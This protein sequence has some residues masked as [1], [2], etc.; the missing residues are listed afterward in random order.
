MG[1][2]ELQ[3]PGNFRQAEIDKI[4]TFVQ[5]GKFCQLISTPG[6]GK[7]T[8]LRLLAYNPNVLKFHLK[9]KG[10]SINFIYLNLLDL[11]NYQEIEIL[12]YILLALNQKAQSDDLLALNKQLMEIVHQQASLGQTTVFLFDHFDEYQNQLPPSFFQ[13]LR[14]ANR[15]ARYK[16]STVFATR[17]DL[18]ELVDPTTIKDFYDFFTDNAIYMKIYDPSAIEF[19]VSQIEAIFK[20]KIPIAD[21][22]SIIHQTGGHTK[23]TKIVTEMLIRQNLSLDNQLLT[24]PTISSTLQELWLF[25]TAQEQQTLYQ[26]ANDE[27]KNQPD[28]TNKLEAF[29][30]VKRNQTPAKGF[31][32]TI[33]L[34]KEYIKNTIPQLTPEKITYNEQTREITKGAKIIS[35]LLSPQENR[36]LKFL[37]ENQN[38]VIQRDEIIKAVWLDS[39]NAQGISDEAIDQMI[40]RLRKKI[41][42]DPNQ[43]ER[44]STVKGQGFRFKA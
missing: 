24:K 41:E 27:Y 21:K 37:I 25:L 19:M 5:T 43:P 34:F 9:E 15:Q 7:A 31:E 44:L 39:Q 4:L 16:F 10:A 26:I 33:P 35:D 11:E 8:L 13:L 22:A 42:D 6:S 23:L 32:L 29:G 14:S 2:F 20:K 17:R 38:K 40:F 30:L 18:A 12:K 36:L 28:E 1:T 3:F